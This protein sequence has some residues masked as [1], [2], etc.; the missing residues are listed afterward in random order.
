[1]GDDAR[2]GNCNLAIEAQRTETSLSQTGRG[3]MLRGG[4]EETARGK[5]IC[6]A[7]RRV[8]A[9]DAAVYGCRCRGDS[10]LVRERVAIR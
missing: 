1:M 6:Q 9:C 10:D 3:L 8:E 5:E 4:D 2:R 7:I